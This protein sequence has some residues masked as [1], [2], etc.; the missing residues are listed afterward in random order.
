MWCRYNAVN[1]LK[2]IHKR[3]P[4]A[5]PLGRGM[6]C[7]LGIHHL[8]DILPE[9]LQSFMQYLAILDRVITALDC[10]I[11]IY[12]SWWQQSYRLTEMIIMI[13]YSPFTDSNTNS[14]GIIWHKVKVFQT[15]FNKNSRFLH[16]KSLTLQAL[17]QQQPT[18][19]TSQY[20]HAILVYL[21]YLHIADT[22]SAP[23]AN[24]DKLI[25]QHG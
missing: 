10:N 9:F 14:A 3:H 24:M 12:I 11:Y 20:L 7:L 16:I 19:P 23:F 17:F 13:Q 8:S 6:G 15:I 4:I 22:L 21:L 25:S 2:N 5:R 18:K 1:F